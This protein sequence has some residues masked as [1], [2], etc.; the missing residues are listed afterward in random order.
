[1]IATVNLGKHYTMS[2]NSLINTNAPMIA[3]WINLRAT[4]WI[5]EENNSIY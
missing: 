4:S 5:K 1:M 2:C 3:Y